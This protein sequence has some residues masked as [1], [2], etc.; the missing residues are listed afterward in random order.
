MYNDF[1]IAITNIFKKI[2]V[3][4]QTSNWMKTS[5]AQLTEIVKNSSRFKNTFLI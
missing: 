2:R 4:V 5:K 3:Y 1:K